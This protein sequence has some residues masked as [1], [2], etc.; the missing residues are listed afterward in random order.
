MA[1][2]PAAL[3]RLQSLRQ[4]RVGIVGLGREGIDL[5][6]FLAP[7]AGEILVSDRASADGL[8][9]A[10]AFLQDLPVRHILGHQ[11]GP[12]LVDCDVVFVSPGVPHTEPVVARAIAAGARISSATR[13]FF[14]LCPGPIIGITGSSGKTTT[15]TM[16]GAMLKEA[17]V[18]SI[19]GGNM[20]VPMLGRLQEI[21]PEMWSVLELSSFQLSDIT[22]SPTIAAILN[23]TPN[24]LDRHPDMADY[25]RAKANIIRYQS[26]RDTAVLNADD[27]IVAALPHES[28][29]SQFSL[30]GPTA[31]AWFENET[32]WL[33]ANG[34]RDGTIPPVSL[35]RRDELP[36]RGIHNV[37]NTLAAALV[38]TAAG[39]EAEPLRRAIRA[40][41]PVP[42][43]LEIV[44]TVRGV[45]YIN[46]SIAT[47]P[48][49]S[50]AALRAVD[51]P[52]VLIAGGRDKHTPMED[53]ARLIDE[54][55]RTI[56]LVGE[57]APLIRGALQRVDAQ[58]PL[59]EATRFA[60][61]VRLAAE[62]AREGD[63]VLLSPGCTS[64]DQ[65]R[66]YEARGAAFREFVGEL[67][68][69]ATGSPR[70]ATGGDA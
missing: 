25:I 24:H 27:P 69:A 40:F 31:G 26:E 5:A 56:V 6:R 38:A 12:E 30:N 2:A 63:T 19:V 45:T 61:A 7:W 23:I 33:S 21:T 59:L 42:H 43:R 66:D 9:G 36:L 18:P 29:A 13:L 70:Q 32:L 65:F 57:A 55:V 10:L 14:E 53:W 22:Q 48:E 49:R 1:F 15:T 4:Q 34:A 8:A 62:T 39:C 50:M 52:I 51:E 11:D 17:E 46:D 44:D 47:S 28:R 60:D 64:F 20:G 54:R 58:V 68:G 37:A 41:R 16:V 35:L 67:R 3:S